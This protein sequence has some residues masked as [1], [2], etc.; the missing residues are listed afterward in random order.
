MA[1]E[2]TLK[3]V[4]ALLRRMDAL[5]K[6]ARNGPN[7]PFRFGL[8][9]SAD[10]VQKRAQALAPKD[11]GEYA[12]GIRKRFLKKFSGRSDIRYQVAP[13]H[14]GMGL[15]L[16]YGTGVHY[17]S[18]G[19]TPRRKKVLAD[20]DTREVYGTKAQ[21]QHAQPHLRPA[22]YTSGRKAIDTFTI[23]AGKKLARLVKKLAQ[24]R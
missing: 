23:E 7:S 21:G 3:G 13:K 19:I 17:N 10:V 8:M 6:E 20:R 24:M 9:K 16:E 11:T 18:D 5:P 2:V 4:D 1:D 15:W 14:R 22:F 12:R